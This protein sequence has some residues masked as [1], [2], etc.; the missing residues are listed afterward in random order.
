MTYSIVMSTIPPRGSNRFFM[1]LPK[2]EGRSSRGREDGR[3]EAEEVR[4]QHV[5]KCMADRLQNKKR[6]MNKNKQNNS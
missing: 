3:G 6:N 5:K 2:Q 1:R 4:G